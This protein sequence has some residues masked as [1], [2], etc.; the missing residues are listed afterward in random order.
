MITPEKYDNALREIVRLRDEL[1]Q[2]QEIGNN[3]IVENA[4]LRSKLEGWIA[5]VTKTWPDVPEGKR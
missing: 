5:D 1:R 2:C 3:L 4:K